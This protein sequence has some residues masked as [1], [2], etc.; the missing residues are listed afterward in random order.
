MLYNADRGPSNKVK[1][2]RADRIEL[3]GGQPDRDA[4]NTAWGRAMTSSNTA[5]DPVGSYNNGSK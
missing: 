5:R 3:E 2:T 4:L 1:K